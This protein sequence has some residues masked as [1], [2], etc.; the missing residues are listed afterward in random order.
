MTRDLRL[1]L[2]IKRASVPCRCP[3]KTKDRM[4]DTEQIGKG[5]IQAHWSAAQDLMCLVRL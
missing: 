4:G 5:T 3:L 1:I 2:K